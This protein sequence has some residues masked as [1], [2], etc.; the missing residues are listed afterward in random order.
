MQLAEKYAPRDWSEYL[1][2]PGAI[3]KIDTLRAH[4]G[5]TGRAYFISGKSGQGKTT[6]AHLIAQEVADCDYVMEIDAETLTP[7][8]TQEWERISHLRGCGR[9]GQVFIIN[10][11]HGLKPAVLR[12]LLVT[13]DTGKIPG[14]VVWI[15]TTTS[16]SKINLFGEK[17]DSSPLLSRCQEIEL[18][19]QGLAKVFAAKLKLAAE[20]EA[21]DGQ[22]VEKYVRLVNDC[23]GNMRMC[24]QKI[25]GGAMSG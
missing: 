7:T 24:W 4:G 5:L 17:E 2:Q 6:L 14:H 21:L 1:G 23:G 16:E 19:C 12:Q 11:A 22:P 13:L 25:E 9:G 15:F 3:K 20:A 8:Q 18:T 10:E